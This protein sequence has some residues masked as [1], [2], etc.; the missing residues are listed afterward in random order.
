MIYSPKK[1]QELISSVEEHLTEEEQSIVKM[2]I[3]NYNKIFILLK[4]KL[5]DEERKRKKYA[6]ESKENDKMRQ[7]IKDLEREKTVL[8]HR[9]GEKEELLKRYKELQS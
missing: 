1:I 3:H 8:Q 5:E 6:D 7:K 9:L 2:I 4:E